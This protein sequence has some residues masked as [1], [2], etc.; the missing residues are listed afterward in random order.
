MSNYLSLVAAFSPCWISDAFIDAV[1]KKEAA[2]RAADTRRRNAV[3][4][5]NEMYRRA[6]EQQNAR[7][8]QRVQMR[9]AEGESDEEYELEPGYTALLAKT[10][11]FLRA[12]HKL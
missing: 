10:V 12:S 9:E 1:D 3:D 7:E 5:R 4:K 8:E 11:S 6:L 2:R